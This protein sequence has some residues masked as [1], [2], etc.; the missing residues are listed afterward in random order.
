VEVNSGPP[1]LQGAALSSAQ[2]S[3]FECRNCGEDVTP[4]R[5]LYTFQLVAQKVSCTAPEACNKS[6]P[7]QQPNAELTRS[8][9]HITLINYVVPLCICDGFRRVRSVK[10]LYLW[11]CGLG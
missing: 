11:N 10:C 1:L 6:L 3:Q 5:L 9:N 4:Y 7:A 2:Q 8:E